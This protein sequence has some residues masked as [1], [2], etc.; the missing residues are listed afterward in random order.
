MPPVTPR[1]NPAP[2]A[3][4]V[5]GPKVAPVGPLP[6]VLPTPADHRRSMPVGFAAESA[7]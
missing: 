3:F 1:A 6:D 7:E 4:A 2:A 5:G